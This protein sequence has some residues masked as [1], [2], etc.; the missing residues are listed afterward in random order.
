MGVYGYSDIHKIVSMIL[1]HRHC[2]Y[3]FIPFSILAHLLSNSK[4]SEGARAVFLR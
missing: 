1:F 2:H 3:I 4:I